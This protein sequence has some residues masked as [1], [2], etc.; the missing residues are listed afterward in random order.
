MTVE[1]QTTLYCTNAGMDPKSWNWEQQYKLNIKEKLICV[2][3]EKTHIGTCAIRFFLTHWS[4]YLCKIHYNT[5][6]T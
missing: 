6:T 3:T 5:T 1:L 4:L 2:I